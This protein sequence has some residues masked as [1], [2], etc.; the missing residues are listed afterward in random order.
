MGVSLN[1]G[2]EAVGDTNN[3]DLGVSLVSISTKWRK[4]ILRCWLV[5]AGRMLRNQG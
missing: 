2:L 1:I 4:G 3:E 5:A